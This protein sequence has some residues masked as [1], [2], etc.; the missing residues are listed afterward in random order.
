ML[1]R[2]DRPAGVAAGCGRGRRD[3]FP[4][5]GS[6]SG[7]PGWSPAAQEQR[8]RAAWSSR[9][10]PRPAATPAGLPQSASHASV[11]VEATIDH[12]FGGIPVIRL[13]HAP[14]HDGLRR[15]VEHLVLEL[16]AAELGAD[17]V[18]DELHELD[19]LAGAG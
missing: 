8:T 7:A 18:P 15:R 2:L 12:G 1:A 16:A 10:R 14:I 9:P 6:G 3:P 5:R 4:R 11:L 17:E 13:E 19:A